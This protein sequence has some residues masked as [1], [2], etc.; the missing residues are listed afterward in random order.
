MN[1]KDLL[2]LMILV[3]I[4]M[5]VFTLAHGDWNNLGIAATGV[6][7]LVLVLTIWDLVEWIIRK[8]K[9]KR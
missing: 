6:V 3:L 8:V 1:L 7:F 4:I 5:A 9:E 2:A